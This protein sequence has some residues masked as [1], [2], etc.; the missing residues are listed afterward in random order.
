MILEYHI[1][2]LV[3]LLFLQQRF[4]FDLQYTTQFHPQSPFTFYT[5]LLCQIFLHTLQVSPCI[6]LYNPSNISAFL[7]LLKRFRLYLFN[8]RQKKFFFGRPVHKKIT[9]W[10]SLLEQYK[11]KFYNDSKSKSSLIDSQTKHCLGGGQT[12]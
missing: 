3:Y 8:Q 9:D 12:K 7:L 4:L 11:W 2:F 5:I 1:C 10:C 6:F